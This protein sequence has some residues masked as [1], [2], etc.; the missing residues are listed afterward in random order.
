[1]GLVG[2]TELVESE[3]LQI[4]G[5]ILLLHH[6]AHEH[7]LI[8]Q[9]LFITLGSEAIEHIIMLYGRMASDGLKAAVVIGEYQSIGRYDHSR[10][11]AAEVD[12]RIFHR[13][14]ALIKIGIGKSEPLVLHL[15]IHGL[16]QVVERPHTLIG[17]SRRSRQHGG[18]RHRIS[19]DISF[20]C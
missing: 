8:G 15:L 11:I 13:M 4:L 7:I 10:A 16:G 19:F 6:E 2:Q 12:H 20:D 18:Q 1:M 5:H 14:L 17:L 9:F 3:F